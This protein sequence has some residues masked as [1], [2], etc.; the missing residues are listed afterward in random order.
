M[1]SVLKGPSV[2]PDVEES[3]PHCRTC[4]GQRVDFHIMSIHS[5]FI[6][7]RDNVVSAPKRERTLQLSLRRRHFARCPEVLW[8]IFKSM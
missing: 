3:I 1:Q 8:R 7:L 6:L 5:L 2:E 4:H